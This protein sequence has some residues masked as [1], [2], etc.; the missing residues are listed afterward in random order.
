MRQFRPILLLP[1]LLL[2]L[3]ACTGREGGLARPP[4]DITIDGSSTVYPISQAVA[5]EFLHDVGRVK[6]ALGVSGTG[7]GFTKF[8]RGET[9]INNA[10]RPIKDREAET[11]RAAGIEFIELAVAADGLSVIVNPA[12]DWADCLT[13]DQLSRIWQTGSTVQLWSDIDPTWPAERLQLYGPG[14][15]SG[16][17]DYF[18]EAI[19]GE[20]GNSR[21]DYS[22][23]ED[24][25]VLIQGV[26][27]DRYALAYVGYAYYFENRDRLKVL[28][29]DNGEGCVEPTP[30]TVRSNTYQPL[31]RPLLIY[32]STSAL[33]PEPD[34]TG[35]VPADAEPTD[36]ARFV[37]YYLTD[38][39]AVI[40]SVGYVPYE[41]SFYR[42]QHEK[43]PQAVMRAD[44]VPRAGAAPLPLPHS[45][46]Q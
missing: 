29:I 2:L 17:F 22:A 32:V 18:T 42:E 14:T 43:L 25:N 46:V 37:D 28:S 1:V 23:S 3:T 44:H 11:C 4:G 41:E 36:V 19:N 27:G 12:N 40:P 34:D 31:S 35:V 16:T 39:V 10:S 20:A 9:H 7:G 26:E 5:E 45:L 24:D 33:L 30:E 13:V 8:C 15:D 38:G 21:G 6:I